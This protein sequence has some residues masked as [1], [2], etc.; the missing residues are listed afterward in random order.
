MGYLY[1]LL[2]GDVEA[3]LRDGTVAPR[4]EGSVIGE[5]SFRAGGS[6]TAS[7]IARSP[8]LTIRWP[9]PGLK[10][11]CGRNEAISHAVNDLVSSHLAHKLTGQVASSPVTGDA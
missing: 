5:V 10:A 1:Y 3:H 8:C 6:A 7:V 4:A 9:Q 11:L 2:K